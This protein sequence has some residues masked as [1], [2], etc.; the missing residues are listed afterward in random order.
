MSDVAIGGSGT[1]R[2][3]ALASILVAV[4]LHAGILALVSLA[5]GLGEPR[6]AVTQTVIDVQLESEPAPAEP[7]PAALPSEAPS[8]S[9]QAAASPAAASKPGAAAAVTTP[10]AGAGTGSAGD[11]VV[12]TPRG[13]AADSLP[14][15]R[16]PAFQESGGKTG[17][18]PSLPALQNQLP[19]PDAAVASQGR[20]TGPSAA[21]SG[22]GTSV[23]HG[24]QG[25]LVPG[26]AGKGSSGNLDLTQ[27]D[28]TIAGTGPAGSAGSGASKGA[29][30][31]GGTGTGQAASGG[32]RSGDF[33]VVWDQPDAS[34]G[35]TLVSHQDPIL[36]HWVNIQGLSLSVT[37]EFSLM[38]NG[39]IS[40]VTLKQSS[41]YA[42]VDS[43]VVDAIRRWRFTASRSAAAI[44]GVIPY[45]FK[46]K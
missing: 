37:V 19:Q 45:L 33:R 10:Q 13:Q 44:K 29:S 17:V 26:P 16:G 42:E 2:R 21:S 12:P 18:A 9:P 3:R 6:P 11:F 27:L 25:T 34:V 40:S 8:L 1:E 31:Q 14:T 23:Q 15:A 39:V 28:R 5:A 32:T 4:A 43:A 35:R 7:A 38:Q 20:N 36:P 30:G 24:G 46:A 22:A 41:G